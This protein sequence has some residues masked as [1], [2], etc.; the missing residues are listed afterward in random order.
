VSEQRA[1]FEIEQA[2]PGLGAREVVFL[3]AG[4]D[5]EAYL[6]DGAWVFRFPK[7]EAVARALR[8]EVALLPKL[9][10][11][12]PVAT[13]QFAYL[14][15]QTGGGLPFAGYRLIPGEPLT[16]ERFA[17][18][19]PHDQEQVLAT[20][21]AFLHGVHTFPVA[22]AVMCGVEETP[23]RAWVETCWT[24]G[25]AAVLPLLEHDDRLAL[26]A[27]I[28]HFLEDEQNVTYTPC[29]LYG[30]FAPE[31]I[32]Y[33]PAARAIAGIIDWGDLTI[34]DP[35]FDLL[36]LYQDYGPNVIRRLLTYLPHPE[37]A[38]LMRKL[39]VLNACDHVTTIAGSGQ[40]LADDDDV[41]EVVE[42]L[43]EI[44]H[45]E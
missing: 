40:D 22:D 31:H 45:R 10:G 1:R 25:R 44:L 42:A 34:G 43:R 20:L 6:I 28:E 16:P 19:A 8:R 41:H 5:S 38:R 7:R 17:A 37:P 11:R 4:V 18:L 12:L 13:P 3:G 9:A 24:T 14:G 23:L 33:D 27:L 32:L 29:L 35:D 36:Y 30:D 2:F 21:A 26:T 39:R 15:H